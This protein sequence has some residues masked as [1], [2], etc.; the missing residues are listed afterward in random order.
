MLRYTYRDNKSRFDF[1]IL[2][3]NSAALL[4]KV[5]SDFN[6]LMITD[7]QLRQQVLSRLELEPKIDPSALEIT[8]SDGVVTLRGSLE[9]ETDL[10]C[11]ER[12]VRDINGVKGVVD[13]ELKVKSATRLPRSDDDLRADACDAIKWLTTVPQENIRISACEGWIE[14]G[15][16]V[17]ST[18]QA[19][20]MEALLREIPGVHG[21]RNRLKVATEL[22]VG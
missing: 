21:V 2:L 16:E 5:V 14:L 9:N 13:D 6:L 17:D 7:L 20:C 15:G 19:Q 12:I 11:T 8:V 22:H 3:L 4:P 10:A 18:H 1:L